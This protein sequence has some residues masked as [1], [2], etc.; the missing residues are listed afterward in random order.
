LNGTN[1]PGAIFDSLTTGLGGRYNASIINQFGCVD[2]IAQAYT[3]IKMSQPVLKM[4]YDTWCINT[5]VNFRNL[6]DTSTTGQINWLWRFGDGN[7]A[8][9]YNSSNT[10]LVGG[11]HHIRLQADQVNCPAYTTTYDTTIDVQIPIAPVI[12]PSVSA[13]KSVPTPVAG[14]SIPG[15]KYRWTPSWGINL[16]DSASALFNYT[17][18]QNYAINLI[19][20]GG[21][22]THDS[23]LVRVFDDKMVELLVPKSFTPNGDGVNDKLYSYLAGIKEFHYFKIYNRFNQLMF[24]TKNYDEE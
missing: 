22:V 16:P 9:G 6:T 1:I 23:L 8:T 12:H 19:S 4:T 3:L 11:V 2:T 15:Y 14:R 10:Y 13:Y 21:C 20:P 24:E 17:N 5:S 18:T 7:T